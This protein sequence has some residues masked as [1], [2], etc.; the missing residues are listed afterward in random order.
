M[1]ICV[2]HVLLFTFRI[3][4]LQ[5]GSSALYWASGNGD[6]VM[7]KTLLERGANVDVQRNVSTYLY[8]LWLAWEDQ[9]HRLYLYFR[10][11]TSVLYGRSIWKLLNDDVFPAL[12]HPVLRH[13]NGLL[14]PE[15]HNK[16]HNVRLVFNTWLMGTWAVVSRLIQHSAVPRAVWVSQQHPLFP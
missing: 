8:L 15:S 16:T 1:A 12:A 14:A 10:Y 3:T 5:G 13:G 6:I 4:L 2:G 11:C 9:R 7:V